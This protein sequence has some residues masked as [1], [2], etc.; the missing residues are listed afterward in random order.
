MQNDNVMAELLADDHAKLAAM[1]AD[2]PMPEM[3]LAQLEYRSRFRGL[4]L[5]AAVML[6]AVIAVTGIVALEP[7]GRLWSG[8]AE[9]GFVMVF[10]AIAGTIGALRRAMAD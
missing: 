3:V 7:A 8:I 6:G 5:T 2:R 9:L 10:L 1:L 4:I